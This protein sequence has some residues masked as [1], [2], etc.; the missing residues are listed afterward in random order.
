MTSF[1]KSAGL[2]GAAL[3]AGI[4]AATKR[5][6]TFEQNLLRVQVLTGATEEDFAKL[7]STAEKMGM[8]TAFSA[9]EATSA[10]VVLAP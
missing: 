1:A 7:K 5:F 10:M 3:G 2:V 4:V 8:T 6:A 9:S